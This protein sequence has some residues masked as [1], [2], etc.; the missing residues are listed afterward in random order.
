ME[1]PHDKI[2]GVLKSLDANNYVTL[3]LM[4]EDRIYVNDEGMDYAQN[5]T[6]EFQI[7]DLLKKS[8][9]G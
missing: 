8:D 2:M 7:Y 5:G 3:E 4:K 1:E 6:P 9:N